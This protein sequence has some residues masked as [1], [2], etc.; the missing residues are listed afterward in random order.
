MDPRVLCLV[1]ETSEMTQ[2]E[3]KLERFENKAK[4]ERAKAK[5]LGMRLTELAF[6]AGGAA[7]AQAIETKTGRKTVGVDGMLAKISWN[8]LFILVGGAGV[9]MGRGFV[10]D[11]SSG[12][13]NV[14]IVKVVGDMTANA[15]TAP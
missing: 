14:G 5:A 2:T 8:T 1:A 4:I 7:A 3:A 12:L 9:L 6:T 10:Q 11:A 15:L 13:L